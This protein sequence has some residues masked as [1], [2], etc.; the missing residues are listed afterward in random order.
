MRGDL[1]SKVS[2]QHLDH[3]REQCVCLQEQH[4]RWKKE[5]KRHLRQRW[6]WSLSR[7]S[8]DRESGRR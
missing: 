7:I 1:T 2:E 6:V 8:E 3:G 4:S 5:E